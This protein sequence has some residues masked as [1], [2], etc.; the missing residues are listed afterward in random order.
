[1]ARTL[2]L[3]CLTI[4]VTEKNKSKP[5]E[6]DNFFRYK[7]YDGSIIVRPFFDFLQSMLKALMVN[8]VPSMEYQKLLIYSLLLNGIQLK[9]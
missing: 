6:F 9:E 7:Q 4:T 5:L 1:M 8:F 3:D 2:K